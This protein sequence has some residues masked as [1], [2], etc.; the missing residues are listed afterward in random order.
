MNDYRNII[1][2]C[3]IAM[4]LI[5]FF[6]SDPGRL[7]PSVLGFRFFFVT[8]SSME[9]TYFAGDLLVVKQVDCSEIVPGDIIT[10]FCPYSE[11]GTTTHRVKSVRCDQQEIEVF[12]FITQ[13]DARRLQDPLPIEACD[14]VGK[15]VR[16]LPIGGWFHR[17]R[18]SGQSDQARQN[19]APLMFKE[20]FYGYV[21][22]ND[23]FDGSP[24]V[25]YRH[26]Y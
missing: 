2:L 14:V 17:M 9:P 24:Y 5:C 19:F 25:R 22:N 26:G 11:Y 8:G 13:G 10:F 16:E 1:I 3:L 18:M 23:Y 20:R 4:L 6:Y 7:P 21:I 15:V 12:T